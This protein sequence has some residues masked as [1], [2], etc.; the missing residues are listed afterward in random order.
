MQPMRTITTITIGATLLLAGCA[1]QGDV[2]DTDTDGTFSSE[3]F[4][5]S[6]GSFSEDDVPF[7]T[8]DVLNGTGDTLPF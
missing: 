8:G 2:L 1:S 5:D 6:D 7:G 4:F 3:S